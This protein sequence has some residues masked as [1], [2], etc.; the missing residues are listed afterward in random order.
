[1]IMSSLISGI[2]D[3]VARPST[4]DSPVRVVRKAA[5]KTTDSPKSVLDPQILAPS[6]SES[7]A[8]ASHPGTISSNASHPAVPGE[9]TAVFP[10]STAEAVIMIPSENDAESE[11]EGDDLTTSSTSVDNAIRQQF[12]AAFA[13]FLYKH[14]SFTTMSHA[15][16]SR[17]RSK[18]LK[19]SAKNVRAEAELRKQLSELRERKRKTELELQRELLVVTRAKATREAELR[20]KIWKMRQT[21]MS[22]DETTK[23]EMFRETTTAVPRCNSDPGLG[24]A[25]SMQ[26]VPYQGASCPLSSLVP[27]SPTSEYSSS[28]ASVDYVSSLAPSQNS[29]LLHFYENQAYYEELRKVEMEYAR[30]TADMEKLRQQIANC[31]V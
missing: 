26:L 1:M 9:A 8:A 5:S 28:L 21:S 24:E 25:G 16:L 29:N 14:P 10:V 3:C 11:E 4:S 18:L 27:C 2:I 15:N 12:E 22:I 20:H 13:T 17:V 7:T 30:I 23:K 6:D 19:E 31:T